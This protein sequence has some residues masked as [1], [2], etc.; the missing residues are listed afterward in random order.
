MELKINVKLVNYD[1]PTSIPRYAK[2]GDAGLDIVATSKE[3]VDKGEFGY[4][5]YGTN[6]AFEIPDGHVGL[7]F[8]RS[9]ISNTGMILGNAVAVIDSGFR[10]EVKLRF[11]WIKDTK[12]YEVG[13][14]V[15]QILILP[16][17]KVEFVVVEDLFTTERGDSGFGSSGL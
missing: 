1:V 5:E 8:P 2:S 16:Y 6:L 4:I 11:K 3:V 10:G 15:A 9:S 14:R 12:Q 13:E 17:P 7:V